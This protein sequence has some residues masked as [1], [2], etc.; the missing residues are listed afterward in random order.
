MTDFITQTLD[1]VTVRLREPHN[2]GF[3]A[4][5][6]KVFCVFDEQDSGN[7][8]FGVD[9]GSERLFVKYAGARPIDSHSEPEAAVARLKEAM[10]PYQALRHPDLIELREHFPVGEGYAAVFTWFPGESLHAHWAFT[11]AEKYT[12]PDSPSCRHKG[13]PLARRLDCLETLFAFHE[14][15]AAQGYVA[16]DF[17]DGSILYDFVSHRTMICDIDLYAPRPYVNTMGRLWGST[18][19][20]SPEEFELGAV[21]DEV[22]NVFTMGATAFA[23]VG[24]E[25][26][27]SFEKW[28]AGTPFFEVACN[29]I[30]PDRGSRYPSIKAFRQAWSNA[31]GASLS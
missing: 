18:R 29:A 26:D 25:R 8:A 31:G 11:P 1:D 16:I 3:L 13:L 23:L 7:I 14:H 22:T 20:M 10:P 9:A 17:Y 21:I 28:E 2:F 19:F 15:V 12:H 6:G 24:G 30:S 27:R 4:D 5:L